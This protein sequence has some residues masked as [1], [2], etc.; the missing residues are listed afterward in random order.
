MGRRWAFGTLN[1][2][3]KLQSLCNTSGSLEPIWHSIIHHFTPY[4]H[5]LQKKLLSSKHESWFSLAATVQYLSQAWQNCASCYQ[6]LHAAKKVGKQQGTPTAQEAQCDSNFCCWKS[7]TAVAQSPT[8]VTY[9]IQRAAAL[10][11]NDSSSCLYICVSIPVPCWTLLPH[12]RKW[13]F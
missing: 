7:R 8:A 11:W 4:E 2:W 9:V 5:K 12:A 10:I 1:S 6:L 13:A 3:S